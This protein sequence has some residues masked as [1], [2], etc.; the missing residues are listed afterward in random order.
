MRHALGVEYDGTGLH[1]WQRLGKPGTDAAMTVQQLLETALSSV[2]AV[3]VDT[4][5]AGRT[6]AG[7]HARCQVVHFDSGL[8][9]DPRGWMLGTTS[10]LPGSVCIRWCVPVAD[11]FHARFSA[12][13]R[14]YCY[15]ILN[16]PMRP[17]I[18]RHYLSWIR[19]PLDADAMQ[20]AA[21][22]LLGEHD[23]SAFRTVHCQAPHARRDLQRITVQ[24]DGDEIRIEVQANA[25][26]HHMVRN[27]VGSLL[28]VGQG[29]MPE[30]WIAELLAG[31][32]RTLAGPTAAPDGLVFVG[33]LYPRGCGLPDEVTLPD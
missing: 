26:L 6:D 25:F 3:P 23:F 2:A 10:R 29:E 16:R 21:R 4:V 14:R 19:R 33:P 15:R 18:G 12:R 5:C 11:D 9:R 24:R 7:V 17:A 20:R 1:G 31:R 22:A 32:D 27:I 30:A 8:H 13:A 28:L